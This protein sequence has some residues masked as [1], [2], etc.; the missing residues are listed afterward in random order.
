MTLSQCRGT[1]VALKKYLEIYTDG[2]VEITERRARNFVLGDGSLGVI[3][4]LGKKNLP[5]S[6][7]IRL[8]VQREELERTKYTEEMYRRKMIEIVRTQIPAH[9]SFDLNCEFLSKA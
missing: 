3:I 5:N 7:I 6:V 2:H 9:V 8:T 1:L 4:A